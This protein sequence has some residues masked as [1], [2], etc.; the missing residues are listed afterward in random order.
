MRRVEPIPPHLPTQ[1]FVNDAPEE[2]FEDAAESRKAVVVC[3]AD[4]VCHECQLVPV[5]V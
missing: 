1:H 2:G 5:G 4:T 3:Y